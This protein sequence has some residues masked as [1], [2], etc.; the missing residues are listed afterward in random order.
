MWKWEVE[1]P[2]GVFVIVHGAGEYHVRYKW[3]REQ[4]NKLQYNVIQGDL[5]G[6]GTTT[7]PRGHINSFHDYIQVVK[8]WLNEAT[9]YDV[10]IILLGHSMGSLI[11]IHTLMSL[12]KAALPHAVVLSSP[13]LGLVNEPDFN[14]KVAAHIL[15]VV[16][17][18]FRFPSGLVPGSGTRDEWM[19]SRDKHDDKLI[20]KVSVRW[21]RELDKAMTNAIENVN[22]FPD[23]PLLVTQAGGDLITNKHKAKEWFDR[24]PISNKYYKEWDHLY[25]EVLNE[26]ERHKVLAHLIGF[27]TLQRS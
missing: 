14:K 18:S 6:Q 3:V 8:K 2:K 11:S 24:L 5:P 20:K 9:K 15:N 7:G 13:C 26:P 4:L 19:R 1:K 25:H 17:P 23:V 27:V 21:Y 16:Y 10:P 12:Q 22:E